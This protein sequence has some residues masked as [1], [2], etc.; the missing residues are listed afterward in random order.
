[1][2]EAGIVWSTSNGDF[3]IGEDGSRDTSSGWESGK[4]IWSS[5]MTG[6]T[7]G[8]TYYVRAYAQNSVGIGYGNILPFR[9]R[10][11]VIDGVCGPTP[12]APK[13][14]QCSTSGKITTGTNPI[15]SPSKWTWVCLGSG[16]GE[17]PM[18]SE[19][20]QPGFKED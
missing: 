15:S 17:S 7:F 1:M 13:H 18:C 19:K 10:E 9:T 12:S 3:K 4:T 14:Y 5:V 2:T 8:P 20:K 11:P 6:L 16:G